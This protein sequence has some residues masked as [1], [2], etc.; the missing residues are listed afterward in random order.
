MSSATQ[1]IGYFISR[2]PTE[3]DQQKLDQLDDIIPS[4]TQ[5]ELT[6]ILADIFLS[7]D[8]INDDPRSLEKIEQFHGIGCGLARPELI[9]VVKALVS[10]LEAR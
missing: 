7:I 2:R 6:N 3:A 1:S 5:E 10:L 8:I 9:A 4:L